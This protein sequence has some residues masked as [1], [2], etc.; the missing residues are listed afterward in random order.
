MPGKAFL[1]E[2]TS[3]LESISDDL[4]SLIIQMEQRI[5]PAWSPVIQKPR[6][7]QADPTGLTA[8]T[9]HH[10]M[11]W[12]GQTPEGKTLEY[13][14]KYNPDNN[15]SFSVVVNGNSLALTPTQYR[16]IQHHQQRIGEILQDALKNQ[17]KSDET[18]E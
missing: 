5:S 8:T 15:P 12:V 18:N 7:G 3:V 1:T 13:T 17:G 2:Y 11:T 4:D 6:C 10:D 14:V 9:K 16:L